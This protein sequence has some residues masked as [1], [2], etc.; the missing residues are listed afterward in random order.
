MITKVMYHVTRLPLVGQL[1]Y[2]LIIYFQEGTKTVVFK[3]D[4]LGVLIHAFPK[5]S[6]R[7]KWINS[8]LFEKDLPLKPEHEK[9]LKGRE[10]E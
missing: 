2:N 6:Q 4:I 1:R 9:K 8:V 7:T 10:K 5:L 3:H